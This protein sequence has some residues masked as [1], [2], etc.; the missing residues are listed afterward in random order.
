VR[1]EFLRLPA[2]VTAV[3]DTLEIRGPILP[4][5]QTLRI[6]YEL[7]SESALETE[8][9]VLSPVGSIELYVEDFG[10]AIDAGALHPA[11]AARDGDVFYPRYLGF[12]LQPGQVFPL[13]VTPLPPREQ[14]PAWAVVLGVVLLAGVTLWFVGQPFAVKTRSRSAE[15]AEPEGAQERE[16]L[17]AALRDLEFDYEL[18][19][20]SATD[21][22]RLHQELEQEAI[23]ALAR[24]RGAAEIAAETLP[25]PRRCDCG[26]SMQ[27]GDRFCAACG[28]SV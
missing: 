4:G 15:A 19:K 23:R 3:G 20:L 21:R 14:T 18:G 28:K 5:E 2:G 6:R 17:R 24:R 25:E 26:R 9:R 8:I 7:S 11:R 22:D 16:A 12:E 1:A 27:P 10:V 13:R